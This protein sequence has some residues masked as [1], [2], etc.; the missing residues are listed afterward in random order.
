MAK[1]KRLLL[2]GLAVLLIS[3]TCLGLTGCKPKTKEDYIPE[4]LGQAEGLYLYYD[5]YRAFTDGSNTERLL[6]DITVDGVTYTT[7]EYYIA[8]IEY[9]TNKKEI[10]YSIETQKPDEEEKY[11]LWHYNYDTKESGLVHVLE[12]ETSLSVSEKYVFVN[13]KNG[14]ILYDGDL[15]LILDGLSGYSFKDNVLYKQQDS[16]FYWWKNREFFSLPISG[17]KTIINEKYAYLLCYNY[18]YA[19]DLHTGEYKQT[20]FDSGEYFFDS[21]EDGGRTAETGD[22]TYFITYTKETELKKENEILKTGCRLWSV[23]GLKAESIYTF[24]KKYEVSFSYDSNAEYLNFLTREKT[25]I[26]LGFNSEPLRIWGWSAYYDLQKNKFDTCLT[27]KT[28]NTDKPE[29]VLRVGEYE[30]YVDYKTYGLIMSER[31]YYLHR[32]KDGKD[33]IMLYA[34]TDSDIGNLNAVLFDD[35]HTR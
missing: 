17:S 32:V 28:E 6:N 11:F 10:F 23:Q 34:L 26:W 18:V 33:E 4:T 3:Y 5:N 8:Q 15:S 20:A 24:P 14:E 9:M 30:F 2:M 12:D 27:Y 22:K 16:A 35:I 19:I 29:K 1:I 13:S 7:D 31:F 25:W 21:L